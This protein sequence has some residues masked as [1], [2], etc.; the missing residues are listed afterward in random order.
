MTREWGP[1][2]NALR[3]YRLFVTLIVGPGLAIAVVVLLA[4]TVFS[5]G[6]SGTADD[7]SPAPTSTDLS[8]P[9]AGTPA[10]AGAA[11]VAVAPTQTP[12]PLPTQTVSPTPATPLEPTST[13]SPTP[14]PTPAGPIEYAIQPDETLSVIADRF[15]VSVADIVEFN[16]LPDAEMVFA[17]QLIEIPTDPSQ[18]KE[19]REAEPVPDTAI[20]I[21]SDGLN[22]RD[23]PSSTDGTVK[24]VAPGGTQLDLTGVV[25]VVEGATWYEVDDG[26][27]VHGDYLELGVSVSEPVSATPTATDAPAETASPS[28]AETAT[29]VPTGA[30]SPTPTDAAT[31]TPTEVPAET[32][33]TAVVVPEGGLNVR[34]APE[35]GAEVVYVAEVGAVLNL[36]GENT[37]ADG[38]TWWAINDGNWVQGQFLRFA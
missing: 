18:L 20:V 19:R 14:T 13:P 38:I 28:P 34:A 24:Y 9:A 2:L 23:A 26:N 22:V 35:P 15:G 6:D 33:L 7:D 8:A 30:A 4:L 27:W 25:Q 37:V 31:P 3:R 17:G 10:A 12:V 36:T 11:V 5:T 16:G 21:P 1:L 32:A 29:P